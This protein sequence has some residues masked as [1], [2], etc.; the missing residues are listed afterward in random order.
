MPLTYGA[1]LG[2]GFGVGTVSVL[3]VC[4]LVMCV[5]CDCADPAPRR[6]MD[7]Y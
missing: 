3:L 6:R 5:L 4:C 2:I 1:A 7:P